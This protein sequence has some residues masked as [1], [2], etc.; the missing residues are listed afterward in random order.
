MV[1]W[2]GKTMATERSSVAARVWR[3]GGRDE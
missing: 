2:K 3:E 1:F